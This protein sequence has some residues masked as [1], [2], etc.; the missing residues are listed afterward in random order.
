[1]PQV[2]LFYPLDFLRQFIITVRLFFP[3]IAIVLLIEPNVL[4]TWLVILIKIIVNDRKVD[5]VYDS[6]VF[7]VFDFDRQHSG[8][9]F[10]RGKAIAAAEPI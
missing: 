2:M 4:L 3:R 9:I 10:C 1:M 8:G 5:T 6:G 7:P